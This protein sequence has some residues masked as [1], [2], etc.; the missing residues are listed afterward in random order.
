MNS[1]CELLFVVSDTGKGIDDHLQEN[2]FHLFTQANDSGSSYTR[3][4]EGAGL[5]IPPGQKTAQLLGKH[6][7]RP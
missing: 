1:Q 5:G 3:K 2:I 4:F 6:L 7:K